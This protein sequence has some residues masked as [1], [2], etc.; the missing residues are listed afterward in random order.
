MAL[1]KKRMP[2]MTNKKLIIYNAPPNA[3]KDVAASLTKSIPTVHVE[4]KAK[5]IELT[6]AIHS[7]TLDEFK[8]QYTR[9]LKDAPSPDFYGLSPRQALIKVSENCIKPNFGQDYFGVALATSIQ[10][11][12]SQFFECSD[13]GFP[14]EIHPLYDI[15][16][17]E[18]ILIVRIHRGG[19][20]YEGDS[21]NYIR[22]CD[23]NPLTKVIDIANNGTQPEYEAKIIDLAQNF[24]NQ[25]N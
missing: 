3:G 12:D 25:P 2:F 10:K 23:V 24:F 21:R 1:H 13:G 19:C 6:C 8:K 22:Q 17:P 20:T 16:K 14:L 5:L 9:E 7:M 18:D 4:F 15:I 11:I